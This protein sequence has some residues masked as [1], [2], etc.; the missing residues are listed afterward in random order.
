[1]LELHVYEL[2]V[3][4]MQKAQQ[5]GSAELVYSWCAFLLNFWSHMPQPG[6]A[7]DE[8]ARDW[9]PPMRSL[10][11]SIDR[12]AIRPRHA[13]L[14]L[15]EDGKPEWFELAHSELIRQFFATTPG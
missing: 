10:L 7:A 14:A 3:A 13:T 9:F 8:V 6:Y 12:R 2:R 5:A 4:C 1:M 15:H 11:A